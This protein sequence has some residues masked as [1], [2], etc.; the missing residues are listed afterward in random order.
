MESHVWVC[1]FFSPPCPKG[2]FLACP[3]NELL[4]QRSAWV[5]WR[6]SS[7]PRVAAARQAAALG[8]QNPASAAAPQSHR[9]IS[10]PSLP[11][12]YLAPG[13]GVT[14]GSFQGVRYCR[15]CSG[16]ENGTLQPQ[17]GKQ[18]SSSTIPF[19]IISVLL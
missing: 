1:L 5:G 6:L 19:I 8:C 3:R 11:P 18:L 10:G 13:A 15:R 7:V 14:Y 2:R 9:N 16:G 12:L 17:G 4:R